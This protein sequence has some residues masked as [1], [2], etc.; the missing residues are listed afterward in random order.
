MVIFKNKIL[1]LVKKKII[2][3]ANK[4]LKEKVYCINEIDRLK[5]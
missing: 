1:E 3:E 4:I 5:S 2:N